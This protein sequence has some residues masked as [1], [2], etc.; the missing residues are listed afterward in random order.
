MSDSKFYRGLPRKRIGSGVIFLN[1]RGQVLL[2]KPSYKG[3]WSLPGG[4]VDLNEPPRA[5]AIRE[6]REEI[7]LAIKEPEFVAVD[8][9]RARGVKTEALQ[10]IFYGGVLR[11]PQVKKIRLRGNEIT[12]WAFFH[13]A[14]ALPLLSMESRKRVVRCLRIIRADRQGAYLEAWK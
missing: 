11:K 9:V 3:H 10:F 4:G 1:V 5:A 14:S 7:G 12:E 2:V 6:V 8:Y 13:A